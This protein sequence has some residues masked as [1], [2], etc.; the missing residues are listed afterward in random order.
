M[1]SLQHH[2]TEIV[3]KRPMTYNCLI[4]LE[5]I[6]GHVRE[7][8]RHTPE[9]LQQHVSY[10]RMI[11]LSNSV[12]KVLSSDGGDVLKSIHS[13]LLLNSENESLGSQELNAK[14]ITRL[15]KWE[16]QYFSNIISNILACVSLYR[17]IQTSGMV[18]H[19]QKELGELFPATYILSHNDQQT[20]T[21]PSWPLLWNKGAQSRPN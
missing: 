19:R 16:E 2:H 14:E 21:L 5:I 9:L 8:L 18:H 4:Y 20:T 1:E 7:R 17:E 15:K 11:L 3:V 10:K 13:G 12:V 6:H